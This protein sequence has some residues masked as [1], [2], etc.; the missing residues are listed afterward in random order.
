MSKRII[1]CAD[2]FGL[3]PGISRAILKL[4]RAQRLS[5]VSCM[6]G[7]PAFE[8]YA[9]ELLACKHQ[10]H[11]GLHFNLT[12]GHLLS[13]PGRPCFSLNNL[14]LKTHLRLLSSSLIAKE[15]N[16]Q[17]D[18]YIQTMGELPDFIDG[19]QHVHQ[20]PQIRKVLFQVYEQRLKQHGTAIRSTYP[21]VT[22]PRYRF[23]AAV[24][25]KTGGRDLS[26]ELKQF[27]IP[28][29]PVF[30]GVYDFSPDSNYRS[31]F[32]TWLESIS[33]NALIMC[34]PGE[35]TDDEI[36]TARTEELR[37]FSS[38]DFLAD[39]QNYEVSLAA[40]PK[41]GEKKAV[42]SNDA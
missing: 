33:D 30:S 9:A 5:A 14:I 2:D 3:N 41:S 26:R 42:H 13:E 29:N 12:E 17:L 36:A 18:L 10:I 20:F 19:H 6:V 32:G 16:T 4:V 23:K 8:C 15:L 21:A 7:F 40:G 38:D 35:D 27:N 24:L 28:H 1:L 25:A 37:Y 34:H 22:I 11:T 39:C 31:L